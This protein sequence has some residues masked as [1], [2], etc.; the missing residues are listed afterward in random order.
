MDSKLKYFAI[1]LLRRGTYKWKPRTA[2]KNAAKVSYGKYKC[3]LC[4][5]IFQAKD[6]VLDHIHP[7]VDPIL[8]WQ[9]FDVYIERMY[10]DESGFQLLCN[11][12]HDKKTQSEQVVR[13]VVKS[14][15]RT[16]KKIKKKRRK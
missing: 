13:Q 11:P 8:G 1:N 7:V 6:T 5:E 9:G 14:N 4:K 2:V 16:A 12:C 3:N 15:E 10:C